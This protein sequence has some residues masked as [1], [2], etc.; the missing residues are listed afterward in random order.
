M[1]VAGSG[2][3]YNTHMDSN[4]IKMNNKDNDPKS[5]IL[6]LLAAIFFSIGGICTKL[7]PWS[8][9]AING[10]RDLIGASV[11]G[12][13]MLATHHKIVISR[14]VI[15][16]AVSMI[17][18]TTCFIISNKLTTAA[19]AIV[20]QYTAPVFVIIFMALIFGQKPK[21]QDIVT[22]IAVFTG[23]CI[24]FVD[25]FR[26]GNIT[27]D[28]I[29]VIAG[30][31]YAGVIMMNTAEGSDALSSCFLGQLAAGIILTPLC[32]RETDFSAPVI[33]TVIIMGVV[34]VGLSYVCLSVG[35][36]RIDA[37]TA[38]FILSLEPVMN[39]MWV[40]LFYGENISLLA[41]AGAVIVFVS[42]LQYNVRKGM[43]GKSGNGK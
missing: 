37:V 16:G 11:I 15:I 26:T 24:V 7:I 34:Q 8:A 22:C 27:G 32:F 41:A 25:G 38:S 12:I 21:R 9:L 29:A 6:V 33:L 10:A 20:L 2:L 40:A 17:G 3:W 30:I 39:P 14:P 36:R 19:N 31:F 23:V 13:Y 42:V 43:D 1:K 5:M 4:D 18:V 28:V 35:T